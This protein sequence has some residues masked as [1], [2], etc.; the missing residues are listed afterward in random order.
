MGSMFSAVL[1]PVTFTVAVALV[2]AHAVLDASV[3]DLLDWD[4]EGHPAQQC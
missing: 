4:E 1:R 2:L 3:P